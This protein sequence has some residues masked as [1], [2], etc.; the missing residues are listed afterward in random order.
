[1]RNRLLSL[2]LTAVLLFT[3]VVPVYAAEDTEPPS[4]EWGG[5]AP[6]RSP[7]EE[8]PEETPEDPKEEP[9]EE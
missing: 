7:E 8:T 2:L 3:A 1:M 4:G 9:S 6:P 5:L